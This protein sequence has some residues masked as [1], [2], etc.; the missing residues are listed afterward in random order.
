MLTFKSFNADVT[1]NPLTA[2]FLSL[3]FHPLEV[4]SCWRDTQSSAIHN[5]KWV[6]RF[7]KIEVNSSQ[8]LL[9]DVTF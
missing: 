9:V 7:Y 1:F 6:F 5:F 4:V 2:K 8:I 3:N